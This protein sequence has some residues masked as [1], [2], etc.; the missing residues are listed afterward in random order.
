MTSYSVDQTFNL[1]TVEPTATNT[2]MKVAVDKYS[3]V[4]VQ[5]VEVTA[6]TGSPVLTVRRSNNGID[7]VAL[8]TP[9]TLTS[10]GMT[11]A[12]DCSGFAFLH[13]TLTT[14]GTAGVWRVYVCAKAD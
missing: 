11:D 10:P 2:T 9:V 13:V 1:F 4:T 6:A 12:I 5:A 8:T 14:A 3:K 7:Q